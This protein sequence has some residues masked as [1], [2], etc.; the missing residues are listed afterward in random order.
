MRPFH[1]APEPR[2]MGE[3]AREG[4]GGAADPNRARLQSGRQGK[5][6]AGMYIAYIGVEV[7]YIETDTMQYVRTVR[8]HTYV[9]RI[10]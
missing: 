2:E 5:S 10:C 6:G 4:G 8:A 1:T 7:L 9:R 3:R